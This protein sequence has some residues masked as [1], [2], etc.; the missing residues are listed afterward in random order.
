MGVLD[1]EGVCDGVAVPE[2][3]GETAQPLDTSSN[4]MARTR[5]LF[6]S[7]IKRRPVESIASPEGAF[8]RERAAGAPSPEKPGTPGMPAA[9]IMVP[10]GQILR[11][12]WFPVSATKT[13]PHGSTATP[14]GALSVAPIAGAKFAPL[15]DSHVDS[16]ASVVIVPDGFTTRTRWQPCSVK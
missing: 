13:L 2:G 8:S 10:F 3:E 6:V 14:R 15:P 9:M 16:P 12:T 1:G 11:T 5:W 4:E 7:V